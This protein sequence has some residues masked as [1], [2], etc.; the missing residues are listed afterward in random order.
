MFKKSKYVT[1]KNQ[2]RVHRGIHIYREIRMKFF[3]QGIF[4]QKFLNQYFRNFKKSKKIFY[5]K[6]PE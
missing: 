5:Q 4:Y 1:I 6:L 3:T 2:S